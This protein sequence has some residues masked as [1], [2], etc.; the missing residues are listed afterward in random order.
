MTTEW[1]QTVILMDKYFYPPLTQGRVKNRL[2]KQITKRKKC[3]SGF[4]IFNAIKTLI[5]DEIQCLIEEKC[6]SGQASLKKYEIK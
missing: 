4:L 2:K 3:L 5:N 6:D 1:C